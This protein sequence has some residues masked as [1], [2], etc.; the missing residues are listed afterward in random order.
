MSPLRPRQP[1]RRTAP[2]ASVSSSGRPADRPAHGVDLR[3]VVAGAVGG[4]HSC[5]QRSTARPAPRPP[6]LGEYVRSAEFWNRTLR[7]WQSEFLAVL[8]TVVL[9]VYLRQRGSPESK[10][11]GAPDLAADPCRLLL[12]ALDNA[13]RLG[14][15]VGDLLELARPE[16][17]APITPSRSTWPARWKENRSTATRRSPLPRAWTPGSWSRAG[18]PAGPP[19]GGPK[20]PNSS[21]GSCG[22]IGRVGYGS[23]GGR[24]SRPLARRRLPGITD[25]TRGSPRP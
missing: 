1:Q 5:L 12:A 20:P 18:G 4:G 25:S 6:Q 9:S 15:I 8:S 19:G 10:P 17:G 11:V 7:N 2:V 16:T 3:A 23:A 22:V 21:R 14:A 13:E 24:V